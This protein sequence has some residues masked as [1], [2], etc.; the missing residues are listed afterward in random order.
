MKRIPERSCEACIAAGATYVTAPPWKKETTGIWEL[1]TV[2]RESE[3]GMQ[4]KE[5][6]KPNE[7]NTGE[8][9]RRVHGG[10]GNVHYGPLLKTGKQREDGNKYIYIQMYAYMYVHSYA[11]RPNGEEL[12]GVHSSW[13]D[14]HY[15]PTLKREKI[16]KSE[17]FI[18]RGG[19]EACS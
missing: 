4:F 14:V 9:L 16:R 3:R 18:Q 13:G 10:W 5:M 11:R 19:R 6:T 17:N 1:N 15:G 12:W 8:G 7:G 2:G